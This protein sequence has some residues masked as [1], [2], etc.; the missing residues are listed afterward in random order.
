MLGAVL[1]EPT[2]HP[3]PVMI[4]FVAGAS[5]SCLEECCQCYLQ[6]KNI[7]LHTESGALLCVLYLLF[8]LGRAE[9]AAFATPHQTELNSD[10]ELGPESWN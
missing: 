3:A 2:P 5:M 1:F 10:A 7:F 9:S 4:I 8:L 6:S